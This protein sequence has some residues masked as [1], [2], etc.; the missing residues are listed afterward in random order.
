MTARFCRDDRGAFAA[1]ELC[2]LSA[3]VVV[4]LLLVAGFGRVSRGRELINQA[5]SAAARAGSLSLSP[6][7]AAGAAR[8]AA[9]QTLATGGLSCGSMQVRLD[10]SR[11]YPGGQVTAHLSCRADLSSLAMAG[12]PGAVTLRADATSPL[13]TY[14]PVGGDGP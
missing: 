3:F 5:A 7:L 12:L 6:T 10:T 2:I 4:M 13:E 1:L 11:W 9:E 8:R 14:R